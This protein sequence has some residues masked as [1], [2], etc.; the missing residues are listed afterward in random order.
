MHSLPP[1]LPPQQARP[2]PMDAGQP[3]PPAVEL[4]VGVEPWV[5]PA[6]DCWEGLRRG[7]EKGHS[8]LSSPPPYPERWGTCGTGRLVESAPGYSRSL[9][10][11]WPRGSLQSPP[12]EHMLYL[13]AQVLS[14]HLCTMQVVSPRTMVQLEEASLGVVATTLWNLLIPPASG[15]LTGPR[16][17]T[18]EQSRSGY[19]L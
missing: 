15:Y 18:S 19:F 17:M 9:G 8:S 10:P 6:G 12:I 13:T 7:R 11:V 14:Q 4:A 2:L 5:G 1:L 16:R 3:V